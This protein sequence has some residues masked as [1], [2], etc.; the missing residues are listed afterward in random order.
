MLD[1]KFFFTLVGLIVAVFAICK[2]DMSP[3]INEG[4]WG[5]SG[6]PRTVKVMREV[7]PKGGNPYSL[8]NNYQSMLGS[9]KFVSR[10]SFQGTLSP[11]FSNVDY[12]AHIRYNMPSYKNQGSPCSPLDMGNMVKESFQEDYGCANG[13]CGGGV[14]KCGEGG[15]SLGLPG[16]G[17]GA[18]SEDPNYVKTMNSIYKSHGAPPGISSLAVGDMTTIGADGNVTQPIVYDR[19]IYA[20]QKSR[21]RAHGDPIRGDLS[22]VPC[23]Y[24]WF[25]PSVNP[26]IDLHEGAM[27]VL[28]GVSNS[29]ANALAELQFAASGGFKTISSGVNMANEF[30]TAL[31]AGMADV[32]V[33]AF[34]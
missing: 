23:N 11:R 9:E 10:P 33:T 13:R 31:G 8:Q 5:N 15:V 30:S 27:N 16:S 20:N 2:T 24:G 26:S 19:Y 25:N 6:A 12:G 32:N 29:T 22:I 3:A 28:G 1:S 21:L 17:I 14:A 18:I 7:H 34:A 4:F